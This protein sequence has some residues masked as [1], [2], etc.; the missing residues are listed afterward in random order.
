MVPSCVLKMLYQP[1]LEAWLI[2]KYSLN[3]FI[4][5]SLSLITDGNH[6]PLFTVKGIC[7]YFNTDFQ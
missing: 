7:S 3:D 1:N 2:V 6:K 5:P 4:Q